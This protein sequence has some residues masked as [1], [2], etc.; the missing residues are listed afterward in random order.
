MKV[1][2]LTDKQIR[3][4]KSKHLR[5]RRAAAH[6]CTSCG[7]T[8]SPNYKFLKCRECRLEA[9]AGERKRRTTARTYR[10]RRCNQPGHNA[11]NCELVHE[12]LGL[13]PPAKTGWWCPCGQRKSKHARSCQ[14][15]KG[16]RQR[17]RMLGVDV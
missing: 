7:E 13:K 9:W 8:L 15:C 1:G 11:L 6:E 16:I 5:Q 14:R 10:C 17:A 2:D 12:A 4:L 3:S